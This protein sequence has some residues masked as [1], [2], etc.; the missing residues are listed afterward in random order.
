MAACSPGTSPRSHQSKPPLPD[1]S[2]LSFAPVLTLRADSTLKLSATISALP[3]PPSGPPNKVFLPRHYAVHVETALPGFRQW[4][5]TMIFVTV[6]RG[7]VR[8]AANSTVQAPLTGAMD[9]KPARPCSVCRRARRCVAQRTR[10]RYRLPFLPVQQYCM[11][12]SEE[13]ER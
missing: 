12:F 8:S 1:S 5:V 11:T 9:L 4:L 6:F 10:Q 13:S 3:S 2:S 7:L